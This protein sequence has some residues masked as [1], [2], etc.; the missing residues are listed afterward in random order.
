MART[1]Q[2]RPLLDFSS[3]ARRL[4]NMLRTVF[5]R[6]DFSTLIITCALMVIPVAALSSSLDF[7]KDFVNQSAS[8][9][10]SLSQLIR[11][12][13]GRR[14][15]LFAGAQSLFGAFFAHPERHLL[16]GDCHCHPVFP[17]A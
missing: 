14:L 2:S 7:S 4:R 9:H 1:M 13:P 6:G 3:F 11:S 16:R 17:R 10:V 15:W 8:W 5:T 12:D